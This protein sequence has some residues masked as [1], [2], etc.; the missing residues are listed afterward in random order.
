MLEAAEERV[1]GKIQHTGVHSA[2]E[3]KIWGLSTVDDLVGFP[4]LD[5][6]RRYDVV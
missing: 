3:P 4:A 1:K 6:V 2:R 5:I